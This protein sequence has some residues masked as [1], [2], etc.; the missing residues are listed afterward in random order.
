[1]RRAWRTID[2][3]HSNSVTKE[4]FRAAL[5]DF[6]IQMKDSEFEKLVGNMTF[7]SDGTIQ[8]EQFQ[9][10]F[11]RHID[12]LVSPQRRGRKGSYLYKS[13]AASKYDDGGSNKTSAQRK[14][15]RV[16]IAVSVAARSSSRR[17][18]SLAMSSND[19]SKVSSRRSSL[20]PRRSSLATRRPT[21][22]RDQKS[23]SSLLSRQTLS[24]IENG[25]WK[26]L[27]HAWA[28]A[29]RDSSKKS[30]WISLKDFCKALRKEVDCISKGEAR[31]LATA[32]SRE[33]KDGHQEVN[34]TRVLKSIMG[35]SGK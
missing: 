26:S 28:R 27:R 1:M 4:E 5:N 19:E 14:M 12:N 10:M 6:N 17:R 9:K 34:F 21:T 13:E 24:A 32:F 22:A 31:D 18:A 11:G 25:A 23:V 29:S 2:T 8:Y 16:S 7:S 3:D 30:G 33:D 35:H 20:V 15:R